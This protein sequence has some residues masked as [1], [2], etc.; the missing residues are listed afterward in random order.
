MNVARTV[1]D[2]L[3][4]RSDFLESEFGDGPGKFSW[5]NHPS[6]LTTLF[7]NHNVQLVRGSQFYGLS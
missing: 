6:N 5:G 3:E 7:M 1:T 2:R 4:L